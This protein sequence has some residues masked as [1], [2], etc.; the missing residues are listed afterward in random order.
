[1]IGSNPRLVLPCYHPVSTILPFYICFASSFPIFC[2]VSLD[3]PQAAR[4][5]LAHF[6]QIESCLQGYQPTGTPKWFIRTKRGVRKNGFYYI[7]LLAQTSL[8]FSLL[9]KHTH[10]YT[11]F[12]KHSNV[13]FCV[14]LRVQLLITFR[15]Q[16][17]KNSLSLNQSSNPYY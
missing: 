2:I 6:F 8:E 17:K 13:K 3:K 11:Q 12:G 10:T 16:E 14:M 4:F 9:G 5:S 15:E 1:M 7:L